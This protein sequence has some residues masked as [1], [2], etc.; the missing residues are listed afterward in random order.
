MPPLPFYPVP[1]LLKP[2]WYGDRFVAAQIKYFA[3][4]YSKK[5]VCVE[6]N[7]QHA[8]Q[9]VKWLCFLLT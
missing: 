8:S 7:K 4:I 9:N 2:N 5:S 1:A 3:V 6:N